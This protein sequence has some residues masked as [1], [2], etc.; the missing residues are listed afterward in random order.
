M[1]QIHLLKDECQ[2]GE[3]VMETVQ[4]I[5]VGEK[6]FSA[7]EVCR[8]LGLEP[9]DG[10][11]IAVG[12]QCDANRAMEASITLDDPEDC[13][14]VDT[15]FCP[16][17]GPAILLS[18]TERDLYEK[19]DNGIPIVRTFLYDRA[20]SYVAY[21]DHNT[22]SEEELGENILETTLIAGGDRDILVNVYRENQY[23]YYGGLRRNPAVE[24]GSFA[25]A[26]K[27]QIP[28]EK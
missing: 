12:Y 27:K 20:D 6:V 4:Y 9:A 22:C 10:L 1:E 13:P 16:S 28:T 15:W 11:K 25:A 3:C 23:V 24:A 7:E 8:R 19:D 17:K 18:H 21:L 5:K 14:S 2:K 26:G